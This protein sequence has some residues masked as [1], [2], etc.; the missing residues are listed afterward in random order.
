MKRFYEENKIEVGLDEAGRG[1][2]FGPL[3]VAGVIMG[4]IESNPPPY[5]IKDSKKCSPKIR[6]ILK[7]YI[8]ENS[9]SYHVQEI[10]SKTIDNIN[11][12]QSTFKGM[13]MC[14]DEICNQ[15]DIDTILV[16]GNMF[17][18]YT[19]KDFIPINH[20]CIPKGDD[21]Y[22]NIAAA[23]ILA[24]EYHDELISKIVS[25]DESLNKYDLLNNKGYGSKKHRE[26][27]KNYGLT[28]YHRKSFNI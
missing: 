23:S 1:C 2:F 14:I 27:I 26:A 19:T 24:K 10:D 11:I 25:E 5:P 20:I 16:D 3:C 17:P 28:N 9:I 21:K 4:D 15:I 12:L 22:I 7:E 8:I 13:H 18:I 6:K